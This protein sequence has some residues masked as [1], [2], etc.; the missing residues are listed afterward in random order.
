M[1]GEALVSVIVPCRNEAAFVD[2]FCADALQQVLPPPWQMELI[3][4][5]GNSRDGTRER[6]RLTARGRA[7]CAN[8]SKG[9]AP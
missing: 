2:A 5:D 3:V 7:L 1:S 8:A 6:L 9:D 4:A